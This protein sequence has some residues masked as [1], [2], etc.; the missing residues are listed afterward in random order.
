MT[1]KVTQKRLKEIL[2]YD[3][4]T[5][6]FRWKV[7]PRKGIQAGTIISGF[8]H[9]GYGTVKIAR[10]PYG[11][12]RLA[13][14]YV[15]G[16]WPSAEIDHING[17]RNDNRI[18]NLREATRQTNSVNSR[19]HKDNTVG[20]KGVTK[21]TLADSYCARIKVNKRTIYLGTF[22]TPEE[23]HAAYAAAAQKYFG[24]F[25]RLS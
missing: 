15:Y 20:F 11:L 9:Y 13:W 2:S 21:Q 7:K 14:L 18:A 6:F 1:A 12:H 23:A 8:D 22:P 24:V 10:K 17:T 3:P 5:G 16:E 19:M 25:A 4:D